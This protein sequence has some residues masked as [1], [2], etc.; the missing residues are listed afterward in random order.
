MRAVFSRPIPQTERDCRRQR[1]PASFS[2]SSRIDRGRRCHRMNRP[3]VRRPMNRVD[4][5]QGQLLV[6]E[7]W[8]C[9][10]MRFGLAWLKNCGRGKRRDG[11]RTDIFGRIQIEFHQGHMRAA[12]ILLQDRTRDQSRLRVDR[13]PSGETAGQDLERQYRRCYPGKAFVGFLRAP[14]R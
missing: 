1:K 4:V 11:G 10:A 9:R 12:R 7:F 13:A 14:C 6:R 2:P 8:F 5:I 3:S